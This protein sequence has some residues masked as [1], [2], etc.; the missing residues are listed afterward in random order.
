M[1]EAL[2]NYSFIEWRVVSVN[3]F[4]RPVGVV[5]HDYIIL[6]HIFFIYCSNICYFYKILL[7]CSL[8]PLQSKTRLRHFRDQMIG[9]NPTLSQLKVEELNSDGSNHL[10]PNNADQT[11]RSHSRPPLS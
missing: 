1:S 5:S 3:T 8:F 7:L 2:R 11:R 10:F 6:F 9:G 4:I